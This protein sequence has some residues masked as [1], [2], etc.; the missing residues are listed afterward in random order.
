[1]KE[2]IQNFEFPELERNIDPADQV[3]SLV[4]ASVLLL[5]TAARGGF[6]KG[7]AGSYLLFRGATGH[8]PISKAIDQ[9]ELFKPQIAS[10][11]TSVTVNKPRKE[12]YEFWRNLE[13]LP[14]FMKHLESV[15]QV[16][17]KTSEWKA[18]LPQGVGTVS[19]KSEI[20]DDDKNVRIGWHSLPGS[21]IENI[22]NVHFT[23]A[24]KNGTEVTAFISYHAPGGKIGGKLAELFNPAFEEMVKEDIRNFKRFMETGE[25]PTID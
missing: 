21:T 7:L 16:D 14:L 1:M 15:K 2:E 23:D 17:K 19:W 22:G 13:N 3:T 4:A 24:G 8:C 18:R 11:R 10:I 20:L 12:V 25:I 9:S 6:W 5:A